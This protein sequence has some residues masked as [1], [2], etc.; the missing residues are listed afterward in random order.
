MTRSGHPQRKDGSAIAATSVMTGSLS[1]SV[2][3][4]LNFVSTTDLFLYVPVY[5]PNCSCSMFLMSISKRLSRLSPTTFLIRRKI[6][7]STDVLHQNI[8]IS[9]LYHRTTKA[10]GR[11]PH[12]HVAS[13]HAFSK[14]GPGCSFTATDPSADPDHS[15][16]F[17]VGGS[18][19]RYAFLT[20]GPP[21][22]CHITVKYL[23]RE[24]FE[25][26]FSENHA[27]ISQRYGAR[28][29]DGHSP[30]I[31]WKTTHVQRWERGLAK[32]PETRH[33][34]TTGGR[35][36]APGAPLVHPKPPGLRGKPVR[37]PPNL[38]ARSVSDQVR[39]ID[40]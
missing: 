16:N 17:L 26:F 1:K 12:V 40:S 34:P 23:K 30:M 6:C 21:G 19:E 15:R 38:P 31:L 8:R 32:S 11:L 29:R 24:D 9:P 10:P 7:A 4:G 2:E 14:R 35:S 18:K 36:Q 27:T 22:D 20:P 3:V 28:F 13:W 5:I 39:P 37:P 33:A 25:L